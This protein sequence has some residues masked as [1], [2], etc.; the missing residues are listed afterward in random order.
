MHRKNQRPRQA[1][2]CL[3]E[4]LY[5][6]RK[7]ANSTSQ[8]RMYIVVARR[9]SSVSPSVVMTSEKKTIKLDVDAGK[10]QPSENKCVGQQTN[11]RHHFFSKVCLCITQFTL[12]NKQ[13]CCVKI[14]HFIRLNANQFLPQN[15]KKTKQFSKV[16]SCKF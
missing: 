13:K 7:Y 9:T 14:Q 1:G 15:T 11:S 4:L 3:D 5:Q 10:N 12:N 6:T 8:I 2:S 16:L